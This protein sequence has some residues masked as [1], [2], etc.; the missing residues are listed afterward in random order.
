MFEALFTFLG[1]FLLTWPALAALVV[2]GILFEY[3][4]ASGFAAFTALGTIAVSFFF[5]HIPLITLG[6]GA[7]AYIAFG[8]FWSFYRYK[9]HA[10]TVVEKNLESSSSEKE[11]ALRDLHPKAMLARI[12]SWILVWPFSLIENFVGD[13]IAAVQ[14]LVSKWFRGVYHKIYDSAVAALK[15]A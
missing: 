2:L 3:N 15:A 11:R 6:L 7:V 8:L 9:R 5:F 12:T 14:S 1:A 13:F 10:A 4:E